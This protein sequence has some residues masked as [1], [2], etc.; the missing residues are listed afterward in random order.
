MSVDSSSCNPSQVKSKNWIS[1]ALLCVWTRA[2]VGLQPPVSKVTLALADFYYH[3]RFELNSTG[4]FE[5]N[6]ENHREIQ[7]NDIVR[8]TPT[9][10][11]PRQFSPVSRD[12]R[13]MCQDPRAPATQEVH[14]STLDDPRTPRCKNSQYWDSLPFCMQSLCKFL[15]RPM[16]FLGRRSSWVVGIPNTCVSQ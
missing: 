1:S 14:G 2:P 10:P 15:D 7:Y 12:P 9:H 16:N 4:K 8:P 11:T 3:V 13:R 5:E 6:D